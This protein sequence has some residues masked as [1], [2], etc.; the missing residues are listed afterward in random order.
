MSMFQNSPCS[1]N[2]SLGWW[3]GPWARLRYD[4]NASQETVSLLLCL[5]PDRGPSGVRDLDFL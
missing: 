2:S 4:T 1:G 3:K 5:S